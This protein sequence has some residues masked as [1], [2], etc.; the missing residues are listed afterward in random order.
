MKYH[1]RWL[2]LW[3]VCY[4]VW[5]HSAYQTNNVLTGGFEHV[6]A[7]QWHTKNIMYH[8]KV[9]ISKMLRCT[10]LPRLKLLTCRKFPVLFKINRYIS[11]ISGFLI[12]YTS[13]VKYIALYSGNMLFFCCFRYVENTFVLLIGRSCAPRLLEFVKST[14]K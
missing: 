2:L 11:A 13:T 8:Q 5:K 3:F 9:F 14:M 1:L 6:M 7:V 4:Q 10:P 12:E